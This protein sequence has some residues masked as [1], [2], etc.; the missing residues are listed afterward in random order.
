LHFDVRILFAWWPTSN[1]LT[2]TFNFDFDTFTASAALQVDLLQRLS[3]GAGLSQS[4]DFSLMTVASFKSG[5]V[6][7]TWKIKNGSC[8]KI[9][10]SLNLMYY[11]NMTVKPSFLNAMGQFVPQDDFEYVGDCLSPI[12]VDT[13][14]P[15]KASSADDED[16]YRSR[17]ISVTVV[18]IVFFYH[19]F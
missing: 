1:L 19:C 5:S 7:V 3:I 11:W 17:I 15:K 8:R 16:L 4:G 13:G 10:Q 12:P 2:Q 18:A 6:R 14:F 9:Q